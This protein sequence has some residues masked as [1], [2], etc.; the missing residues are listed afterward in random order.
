MPGL[1]KSL[2][3]CGGP[4]LDCAN[5]RSTRSFVVGLCRI[6]VG[7]GPLAHF[8]CW[9]AAEQDYRE[10]TGAC[11]KIRPPLAKTSEGRAAEVERLIAPAVDAMGFDIVQVLLTGS[12]RLCLQ[13]MA[14]RKDGGGM[15]VEDCVALS[16]TAAAILEVENPVSGAFELE[17]SSP[18]IDRPLTRLG[19]FERFAGLEAKIET[20]LP[21]DGR[22][23]WKGY[24]LGVK[25]ETVLLKTEIGEIALPFAAIARA[26]LMLTDDLLAASRRARLASNQGTE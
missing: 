19:D 3:R 25:D 1:E 18:G 12:R 10:L 7:G 15:A 11:E 2:A 14:E 23:R 4:A 24:L 13:I 16:R 22:R 26:K 17:V 20:I 5:L 21:F 8:F 6:A 9:T